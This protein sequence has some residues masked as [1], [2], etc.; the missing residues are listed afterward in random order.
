G[1]RSGQGLRFEAGDIATFG[2]RDRFD[3]VFS[4][5]A[6]QWVP[7]HTECLARLRAGL[8]PGGQLAVQVPA[9]FDHPSHTMVAEVAG[10]HPFRDAM[11]GSPSSDGVPGVLAPERYA[12]LLDGLGFAHQHV[13]LQVYGHH[14]AS[15]EAVIEWTRGT[16]LVPYRR[17]LPAPM[18]EDFVGRYRERLLEALGARSPYFYAF[19]RILFWARLPPGG[20]G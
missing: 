2:G 20:Y 19:K 11:E 13:R 8:R 3:L 14:L 7:N 15:T 4:N 10:E 6:L 16:T 17:A 1:P 5:A 12:G 18:F 9:N